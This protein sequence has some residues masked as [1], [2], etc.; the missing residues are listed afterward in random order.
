MRGGN[1]LILSLFTGKSA[2]L[3]IIFSSSSSSVCVCSDVTGT[4]DHRVSC[5]CFV[6]LSF[7]Y[8][9]SSRVLFRKTG[10]SESRLIFFE[11]DSET[12]T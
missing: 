1:V 7:T 12:H 9:A 3:K 8:D 10:R 6:R 2:S 11:P 5:Y 4:I